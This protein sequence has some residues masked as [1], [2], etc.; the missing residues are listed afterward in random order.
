L[1]TLAPEREEATLVA[2]PGTLMMS[3][4]VEV[5]LI[6]RLRRPIQTMIAMTSV[7]E[8]IS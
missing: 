2:R 6:W 4:R 7:R 1:A 3:R 5:T 8:V